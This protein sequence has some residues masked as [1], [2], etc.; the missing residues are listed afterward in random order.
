MFEV[1]G[2]GFGV[3]VQGLEFRFGMKGFGYRV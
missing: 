1:R 2:S 3:R